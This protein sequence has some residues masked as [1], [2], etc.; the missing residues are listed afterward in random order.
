MWD[1]FRWDSLA[2]VGDYLYL[3][4]LWLIVFNTVVHKINKEPRESL[5]EYGV[6]LHGLPYG[7]APD[8]QKHVASVFWFGEHFAPEADM[9]RQNRSGDYSQDNLFHTI[10]GMMGAQSA[11]YVQNLDMLFLNAGE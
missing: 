11:V 4:V 2:T 8:A 3:T 1:I 6:Y 9:L 7:M 5:G 10:L